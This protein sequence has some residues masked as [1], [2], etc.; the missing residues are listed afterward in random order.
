MVPDPSTC[1]SMLH[2]RANLPGTWLV[3]CKLAAKTMHLT[4]DV[5]AMQE[6]SRAVL[7]FPV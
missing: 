1:P 3:L 7:L 4:A 2:S 6:P 5:S